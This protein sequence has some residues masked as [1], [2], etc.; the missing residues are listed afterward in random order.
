MTYCVTTLEGGGVGVLDVFDDVL[1]PPLLD[2][3]GELVCVVDDDVLPVE[4]ELCVLV[5]VLVVFGFEV[6]LDDL[7]T[8]CVV[9]VDFLTVVEVATFLVL[10]FFVL[11]A[12]LVTFGLDVE[13]ADLET[14]LLI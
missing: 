5:F 6:V 11:T 4:V 1:L 12:V 14:T 8:V 7:L 2:V 13:S 9:A 10:S 3:L